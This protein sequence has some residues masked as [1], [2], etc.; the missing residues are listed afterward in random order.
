MSLLSMGLARRQD[1]GRACLDTHFLSRIMKMSR[2][3]KNSAKGN[4][5]QF[6]LLAIEDGGTDDSTVSNTTAT[7][8]TRAASTRGRPLKRT[9]PYDPESP[10]RK[11]SV[12]T[13]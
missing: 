5:N 10:P 4:S 8:A 3:S 7:N 11:K 13:N 1:L 9:Q 12:P 6:E 2:N